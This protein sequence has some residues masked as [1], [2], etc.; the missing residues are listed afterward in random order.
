MS[1]TIT[2]EFQNPYQAQQAAQRLRRR[3]YTVSGLSS[4][5][6]ASTS[7]APVLVAYPFGAAG[8]NSSGN[9]LMAGLPPLAGNGV[10]TS[11]KKPLIS[12]LTDDTQTADARNLLEALG[13]RIL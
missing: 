12:V 7:G 4:Q 13:G 2:C 5:T 10:M 1:I 3:G 11:E 6:S 8:G 9:N